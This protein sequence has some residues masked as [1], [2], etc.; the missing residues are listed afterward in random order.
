[1]SPFRG[2]QRM[3]I[4]QVPPTV[5]LWNRRL[6]PKKKITNVDPTYIH[7]DSAQQHVLHCLQE[8]GHRQ[9]EV[10]FVL[11]QLSYDN[12][13]NKPSYAAAV[14]LLNRSLDLDTEYRRGD[15]DVIVVHRHYGILAGEIKT[16]GKQQP[17]YTTSQEKADADIAKRVEGAVKQLEKSEKVVKHI[18]EDFAPGILEVRGC[19]G[20]PDGVS[21]VQLCLCADQ[22]SDPASPW[23]VTPA[24]PELSAWWRRR[25]ACTTD[26]AMSDDVYLNMVSRLAGPATTVSVHC[27]VPPRVE[28]R[29]EGEA[30]SEVGERMAR[31][32]LTPRQVGLVSRPQRMVCLTGPPGTGK[33]LLLVL[34]GLDWLWQGHDVHVVSWWILGLPV[35][36]LIYHQ[37]Q[38]TLQNDPNVP[39]NAG[40][41]Y[42]HHFDLYTANYDVSSAINK[43]VG[44]AKNG[45]LYVIMDEASFGLE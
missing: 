42:F 31:V 32:V 40:K 14:K 25:M 24:M 18:V 6:D 39:A 9:K 19:L 17:L 10:M 27:V 15:F 20:A 43:L 37:L 41:V 16:V 26:P 7:D 23:H 45:E 28:V 35:S 30:V 3:G 29:T 4:P 38:M 22:M 5:N 13:L 1:M 44:A 36:L 12:Y 2:F 11:S 33:T 8:L 21:V 34:I